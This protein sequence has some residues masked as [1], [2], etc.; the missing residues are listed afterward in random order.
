M[1][2]FCFILLFIF[3][4]IK[5]FAQ[6]GNYDVAA[7][8]EAMK[9][10]AYSVKRE[11][12]IEFEVKAID[13]AYYKVHKVIT[14]LSEAG[15]DEFLFYEFSDKF[16]SLEEV[17]IQIFDSKGKSVKKYSKSDLTKQATGE[18]LVPDGKVYYINPPVAGYPSTIKIDYELKFN[19]TLDYPDFNVQLPEQSVENAV[20]VAK[21]PPELDLRF[22]SKNTAIS[23]VITSD[24]KNKIYTW[25]VNNLL[26]LEYEEGSV[27]GNNRFPKI[28]ISPNKFE[29]D[30]YA[31]DMT[32]W[33]NFG[34]WY[35][36]LT[37]DAGNIP[38]ERKLFFKNMVKDITDDKEKIKT[39][40]TYLQ[41]NFRYVSIQLGIGGFKPFDADFVDKK[42]YGDCKALSNYMQACLTAV[43][44]KSYQALIN[45]SYNQAPV[46]PDFPHNGFNHDI[47][48]VLA[49]KDSV[50]LEC[51][52][53][54]NDFGVLGNFTENKNALLITEDGGKLVA[55]PKSKASENRFGC[56]SLV[57]LKEDASGTATV[58]L[59]SS[60]EYRQDFLN[61]IFDQKKDDQKKFLV[62]Y[63][64]FLQP[65]DFELNYDKADKIGPVKL[66]LGIEKIP[67]FTAG[68]K[69]FLNPRIYK[70]W[71]S[72]L[73]KAENRTQ[74][75]YFE[76]PF[77][78]TD[79]TVYKLPEG[80]SLE[81]LPKTKEIKFEYGSFKS[82]YVYDESKKT[83]TT[84][85]RLELTE[86]KIPAAKFLDTKKFFNEVMAEYTE[87][88]VVKKL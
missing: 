83:I 18:G 20:F 88:I 14:V 39:I 48:C 9:K 28:L 27:K 69:Q 1:T 40:Y 2:K 3:T 17:S 87:K 5:L 23:P 26:A 54:T 65:D 37:K 70:I 57:T 42:K 44:L 11:E 21:V 55:T 7:I 62:N 4:V 47:L 49:G 73:P 12:R 35:A 25:T 59:T 13:K 19:G 51:T 82:N 72:A 41:N 76:H 67:E 34:K 38:E 80:Y 68:N 66:Q 75:F 79:T 43:G 74:D 85:A 8:T 71:R 32:S 15:K 78:K 33:Q 30:G 58:Q 63:I 53:N 86:Y 46:D 10:N 36:S 56:N 29:L 22:K 60:G 45:A 77:I 84:T 31:G 24:D 61:Y 52:S 64:G 50:W 16:H 81:T 6:P